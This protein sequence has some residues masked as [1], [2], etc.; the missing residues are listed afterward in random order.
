MRVRLTSVLL[1]VVS[2]TLSL[3]MS[4]AVQA[5]EPE[6]SESELLATLITERLA[7]WN[8]LITVDALYE[9]LTDGDDSNDPFIV[10]VRDAEAYA[11]G[12]IPGAYNIPLPTLADPA[13]LAKLP[14][15]QPIVTY[16]YTGHDGQAA[17]TVLRLLGYDVTNLDY[18]MMGWTDDEEVLGLPH[19]EGP[20]GYPVETGANEFTETYEPPVLDTGLADAAEIAK[21]RAQAV[22]P[23]WSSVIPADALFEN[24]N[25][26]DDSND[27]FI[28]SVRGAEDYEKGHVPGA[29]NVPWT[30]VAADLTKYPTDQQI[31]TYCYNG[32]TGEVAAVSLALLG[33]DTTD[34]WYDMMG[35]TDDE[36][37]LAQPYFE[38]PAGY[39]VQTEAVPT[40]VKEVPRSKPEAVKAK[41]DAGEEVVIVDTRSYMSDEYK[42]IEGATFIPLSDIEPGNPELPKDTEI[43]LYCT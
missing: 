34:L 25:D 14:I 26:G 11:N 33:Y 19:F 12:H 29:Y 30:A 7:E 15:D 23:E 27:P 28:L 40:T 32:P 42:H 24:L 31:V 41:L 18:G 17:A 35:W 20:A 9:N 13:N 43:V 1:L 36:E 37:V 2:L 10:S 22:L 6:E 4:M 3:A 16:C 5:E 39:P 21:A 8:P 38:G